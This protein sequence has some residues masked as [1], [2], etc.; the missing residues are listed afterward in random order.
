MLSAPVTIEAPEALPIELE[1]A[2]LFLKLDGDA[3]DDDIGDGLAA[4]IAEAEQI[5]GTRLGDQL[6]AIGAD[7]FSDLATLNVGPVLSISEIRYQDRAG[8]E[9]L[10]DAAVY[11]LSG[12]G[13]ARGIRLQAGAAWPAVRAGTGMIVVTL[14]AGYDDATL[15]ADVRRAVLQQ[16]RARFDGTPADLPTLL[17]N[18]R[19][20]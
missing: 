6:V 4:A 7:A 20:Y 14:R 8:A 17:V 5:T 13:L 18:H 15:P 10:L 12:L 19:I 3:L 11:E 2:K 1:E 9:Q 16:L